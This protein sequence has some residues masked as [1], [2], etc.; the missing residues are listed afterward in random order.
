MFYTAGGHTKESFS[1]PE[2][3]QHLNGGLIWALRK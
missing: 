1:E 2:F 3:V